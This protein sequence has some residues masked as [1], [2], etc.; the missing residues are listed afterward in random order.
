MR[1]LSILLALP[2]LMMAQAFDLTDSGTAAPDFRQQFLASYGVNPAIEPE[3]TQ[4]DRPLYERIEPYLRG[5]PRQ[6]IRIVESEMG[7]DT[8]AAFHFLRGNLYYQT[9]QYD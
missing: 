7:P 1:L 3:I 2:S 8:N 5:D 9:D 6:A 4:E